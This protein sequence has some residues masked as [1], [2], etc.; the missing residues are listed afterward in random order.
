M[1]PV[2]TTLLLCCLAPALASAA[3]EWHDPIALRQSVQGFLGAQAA[4]LPGEVTI[5]MAPLDPR[6]KVAACPA[7]EVFLPVGARI[8]GRTTV[9][10]RCAGPT[11]WTIYVQATVHV[12]SDYVATARPLSQGHVLEAGDL[13]TARGDLTTLP[14]GVQTAMEPLIGRVVGLSLTMG[15]PVRQD[16]L[17]SVPV[18]QQGQSVRVV[19]SGAGFSISADGHAL[20]NAADGQ[21]GQARMP[22]GIVVSGIARPGAILEVAIR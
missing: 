10:V 11:H 13:V 19:S 2:R 7:P 17:K 3:P 18:I 16:A 21:V 1:K 5:D 20:S 8:W 4:G 22:S 14:T 12:T 9:G 15:T 6:L